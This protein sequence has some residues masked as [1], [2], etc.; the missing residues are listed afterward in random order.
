[1]KRYKKLARKNA[2]PAVWPI[3]GIVVGVIVLGWLA[4]ALF[5]QSPGPQAAIEVI[6]QPS[7]KVNQKTLDLGTVKLGNT[8]R[9][10]FE[11]TNV[12]DQPL[13]FTEAPYIEVVEGC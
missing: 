10:T 7:L 5:S 2:L 12:G 8:V 11:L 3:V 1:M 4:W 9:A 6:G 13:R